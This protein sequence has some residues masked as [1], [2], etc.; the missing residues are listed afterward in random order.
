M[1]CRAYLHPWRLCRSVRK[2][3]PVR[4][5]QRG[6]GQFRRAA[7]T[8]D[9]RWGLSLHHAAWRHARCGCMS[10]GYPPVGRMAEQPFG[11]LMVPEDDARLPSGGWDQYVFV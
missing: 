4:R 3:T 2:Y 9:G 1:L 10:V 7:W 11:S 6:E 5:M 8:L